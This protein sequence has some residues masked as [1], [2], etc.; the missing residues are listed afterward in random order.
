MLLK[1]FYLRNK[2]ESE[3]LTIV[4]AKMEVIFTRYYREIQSLD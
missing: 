4:K 2:K 1:E 3:L